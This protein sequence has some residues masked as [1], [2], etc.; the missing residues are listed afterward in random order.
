MVSIRC[1]N[2]WWMLELNKKTMLALSTRLACLCTLFSISFPMCNVCSV[3]W[4]TT[5]N[6]LMTWLLLYH[7]T[8]YSYILKYDFYVLTIYKCKYY[9]YQMSNPNRVLF[10]L[11]MMQY[12]IY[13]CTLILSWNQTQVKIQAENSLQKFHLPTRITPMPLRC[14]CTALTSE[15]WR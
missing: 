6:L 14:R 8:H 9:K 3:Q 12:F 10:R 5:D 7:W 4:A 15:L 11:N 2:A 13:K 1:T